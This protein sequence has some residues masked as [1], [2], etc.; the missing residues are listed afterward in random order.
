MQ[1]IAD[2]VYTLELEMERLGQT[3]KIYPLLVSDEKGSV[4]IDAG[5][6]TSIPEIEEQLSEI[7]MTTMDIDALILTHQDLDISAVCLVLLPSSVKEP[8][9]YA[10]KQRSPLSKEQ[11]SSAGSILRI[12]KP[13]STPCRKAF[14][15]RCRN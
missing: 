8:M 9:S 5:L 2:G 11:S 14:V 1:K 4:L 12:S 13:H 6:P 3:S 7:D 15:K 10:M